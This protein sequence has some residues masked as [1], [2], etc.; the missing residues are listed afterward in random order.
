MTYTDFEKIGFSFMFDGKK[1]AVCDFPTNNGSFYATDEN[2]VKTRLHI[3][4]VLEKSDWKYPTKSA[5]GRKI[6]PKC[7]HTIIN[8]ENGYMLSAVCTDC[9]PV[10][11]YPVP[12]SRGTEMTWDELDALEAMCLGSYDD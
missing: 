6:C 4:E 7:G 5:D 2:G 10:T 12:C 11:H 9:S 1:Y 8:G 3:T